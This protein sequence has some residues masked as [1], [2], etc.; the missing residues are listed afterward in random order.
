MVV[1]GLAFWVPDIAVHAIR[2]Y[3]FSGKDIL[4]LTFLLPWL[5][6]AVYGALYWFRGKHVNGPSIALFML[7]GIWMLGPICM[8][9]GATFS[10]GGFSHP[11]DRMFVVWLTIFTIFFPIYTFIMATYDGTLLGLLLTSILLI[12]MHFK[13]ENNQWLIPLPPRIFK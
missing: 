3:K 11:V 1:G 13:F 8:T 12:I 2:A 4:G 5:L 9:I 6:L 10:G 7:L